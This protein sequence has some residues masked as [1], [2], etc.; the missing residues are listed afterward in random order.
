MDQTQLESWEE[1]EEFNTG[2]ELYEHH[3]FVV[4][5]GQESVRIDKFL[6]DKLANTSRNK[7]QIA[8]KNGN[9]LVNKKDVK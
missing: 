3:K 4:D 9:I 6:M 2:E 7:I 5:K 1:E 8:A